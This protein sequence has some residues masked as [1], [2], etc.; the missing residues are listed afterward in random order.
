MKR[1]TI[2]LIIYCLALDVYAQ[3]GAKESDKILYQSSP[4]GI[5]LHVIP[6][7]MYSSDDS[8]RLKNLDYFIIYRSEI[9]SENNKNTENQQIGLLKKVG[10]YNE[11]AEIFGN[12]KLQRIKRVLNLN[13]ANSVVQYF[14]NKKNPEQYPLIYQLIETKIVAGDVY[15]DKTAK[16]ETKYKYLVIAV[17]KNGEQ[18]DW[19]NVITQNNSKD[20]S[21]NYFKPVFNKREVYDSAIVLNWVLVV[22][23]VKE[24]DR[25][26]LYDETNG[27][28][29]MWNDNVNLYATVYNFSNGK[30]HE[31]KR[32]AANWNEELD[33][34]IFSVS[35]PA[36]S[37]QAYNNFIQLEDNVY[38]RGNNSDTVESF[39]VNDDNLPII[40]EIFITDTVDA[41]K[42]AWHSQ[43]KLPFI[44]AVQ[45][46]REF[47]KDSIA[48]KDTLPLINVYDSVYYDYHILPGIKYLYFAKFIYHPSIDA[49]QSI[50]AQGVGSY[51]KFSKP[52]IPTMLTARDEKGNNRLNWDYVTQ[53]SFY[54][55]YVYRGT[56]PD[57]VKLISPAIFEK[58]YLD[59]SISL[60][61]R[62]TYY[63]KVVAENLRNDTSLYSDFASITPNRKVA[64][65]TASVYD[66][67]YENNQLHITWTD[68]RNTDNFVKS[69]QLYR[70]YL[71]EEK[72]L[73][74]T[75]EPLSVAAFTDKN[76][77]PNERIY[78]KAVSVSH[79]GDTIHSPIIGEFFLPKSKVDVVSDFSLKNVADGI[80]ISLPKVNYSNR[81][82]YII[83]R[84]KA[85]EDTFEKV[86]IL[87]NCNF[88][89]VDTNVQPNTNYVY[90]IA[91][92]DRDGKE[93]SISVSKSIKK[94]KS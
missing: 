40:K 11:I 76:I 57:K 56:N 89:L 46:I 29:P 21:I 15:W 88:E 78:Y 66:F 94:T 10:T 43:S 52:N 22:D 62:L 75:P 6:Q 51:I 7:A 26:V 38:N 53:K 80:L 68:V 82:A 61:P 5:Y 85:T 48:M 23:R 72:Y 4:K 49:K 28:N 83:Y 17:L 37:Y 27:Y 91:I 64:F 93:G 50:P 41:V 32:I 8:M 34:A 70:R 18:K 60:S 1:K 84:R 81:K 87:D 35:I 31:L 19:G 69:Y 42:I 59:T 71:G 30:Y 44:K 74:L 36:A 13:D 58:T 63:Y 33:T 67:Y 77:K 14:K 90:A 9:L 45:I 86:G 55:Y 20:L 79:Q 73:L 16:P 3:K 65:A 39:C 12:E 2:I 54:A 92:V 25:T 47:S 24:G